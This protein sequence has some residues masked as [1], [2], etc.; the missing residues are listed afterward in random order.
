MIAMVQ[1]L[2]CTCRS[3]ADMH[4]RRLAEGVASIFAPAVLDQ[5]S[6]TGKEERVPACD[7]GPGFLEDPD[8][9]E[10]ADNSTCQNRFTA[11]DNSP[12]LHVACRQFPVVEALEGVTTPDAGMQCQ[13]RIV[14]NA[15]VHSYHLPILPRAIPRACK[16][17]MPFESS[18]FLTP[19]FFPL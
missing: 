17:Q 15:I 12:T 7:L 8:D 2:K 14:I 11:S 18:R 4:N 9:E 10:T 3:I 5:V 1:R 6:C 16:M 13:S 19:H